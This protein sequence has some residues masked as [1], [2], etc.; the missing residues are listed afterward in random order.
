[1]SGITHGVFSSN[2]D[3]WA[4]PQDLFDALNEEFHFTLDVCADQT[5]HKVSRYFTKEQNGLIQNWKPYVS[6][7][8]P[9][10]GDEIPQWVHKARTTAEGGGIVVG[11]LP[12]RTDTRWWGEVMEATELRFIKGRL[13]FGGSKNCAPFPSVIAVWG[14]PRVPTITLIDTKGGSLQKGDTP[15]RKK[16][17]IDLWGDS[18]DC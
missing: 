16:S 3:E 7:M 12:A 5:N 6:W 17:G 13:K 10:Y 11:L 14:T 15:P 1:M 8:N 18:L 9:P 2:T 4:T